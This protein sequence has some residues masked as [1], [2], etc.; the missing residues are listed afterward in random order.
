MPTPSDRAQE[1]ARRLLDEHGCGRSW[2][3][4]A[5]E[6]YGNR[7]NFA[8]LNRFALHGG[9]WIPK[10][11][12]IQEAL[13]LVEPKPETPAWLKRRKTAIAK[14]AKETRKALKVNP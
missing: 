1:T 7:V 2:R 14:M 5:R 13:G 10:D 12:K 11:R 9:E 3:Q 4:I 6:D 8:T